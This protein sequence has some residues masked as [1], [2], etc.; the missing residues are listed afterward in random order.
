MQPR[1]LKRI[2]AFLLADMIGDRDLDVERDM[3]SSP[4]LRR[5]GRAAGIATSLFFQEKKFGCG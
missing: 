2:K 5:G 4:C 3:S 1:T